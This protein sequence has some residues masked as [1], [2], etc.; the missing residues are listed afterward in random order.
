MTVYSEIAENKR[1][2]W[3]LVFLFVLILGGI[4][5]VFGL[6]T[7]S[8]Y[9]FLAV[10]L[11]SLVTS[12]VSYYFGDTIALSLNGATK[13]TETEYPALHHMVENLCIAT[14]LPI[15]VIYVIPDDSINAFATGRD[16]KHASIAV[17][18]GLL[19]KLDKSEMEGV[20]GHEL[21]HI[22]NYDIRL[23]MVVAI[24]LGL[25]LMASDV[26]LR[27]FLWRGSGG[28]DNKSGS[29]AI[30]LLVGIIFLIFTPVLTHILQMAISRQREYMADAHAVVITRYPQ[31]LISALVKIGEEKIPLKTANK[32]T[33]HL[34]ISNPFGQV[35]KNLFSTHPAISDRI[36]RLREMS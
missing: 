18:T 8:N 35:T 33:A 19:K 17:T 3:A 12:V 20:I 32:A 24:L 14:G 6:I 9:L 11:I 23:S 10:V 21:S 16:P 31:G 25:A 4:G 15:P 2:T 1:N 13:T 27:S 36:V 34:F 5:Y 7:D 30:M 28:R 22:V 29:N 26:A